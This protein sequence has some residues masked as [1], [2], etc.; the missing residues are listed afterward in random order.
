MTLYTTPALP[1]HWI[2]KDNDGAMWIVPAHH[3]GWNSKRPYKGNYVLD[4]AYEHPWR[5]MLL[6]IP[7]AA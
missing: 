3:N 7:K 4:A 5:G 1:A 6:G 2:V